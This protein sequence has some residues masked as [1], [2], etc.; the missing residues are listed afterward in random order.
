MIL[1][2]GDCTGSA[3][4]FAPQPPTTSSSPSSFADSTTEPNN[5]S[6]SNKK[7][8]SIPRYEL[9][10]EVECGATVGSAAV[11]AIQDGS[12]DVNLFIPA[13]ELNKVC[14]LF[15]LHDA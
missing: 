6:N 10:F 9:A 4:L 1:L 5:N 14:S 2:A 7:S 15:S 8:S 13:Y 3:Y 11:S 12:G